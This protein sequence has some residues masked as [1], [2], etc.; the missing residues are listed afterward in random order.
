MKGPFWAH[1]RLTR[2][3]KL[4]GGRNV[5]GDQAAKRSSPVFE[6]DEGPAS[7]SDTLCAVEDEMMRD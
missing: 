5:V 7:L 6:E 2:K 1:N 3:S 4:L